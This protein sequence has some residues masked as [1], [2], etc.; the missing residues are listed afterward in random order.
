[1]RI[2]WLLILILALAGCATHQTRSDPDE[3]IWIDLTYAFSSETIYWPSSDPFQLETVF[4]GQT[5]DGFYYSAYKF[6]TAE[7][8][9][10]HL[11]APVHFGEGQASNAELPLNRLIGDAVVINATAGALANRDYLIPVED[12]YAWEELHGQIP[13]R[14]IVLLRTGYGRYWP[15]PARSG[16]S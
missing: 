13:A 2:I 16:S 11:D 6:S 15:D 1:M 14:A 10:T 8:G 5:Q 3:E 12:L 4:A 7:H 9:G